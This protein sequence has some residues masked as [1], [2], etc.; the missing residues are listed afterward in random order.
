MNIAEMQ[1][2]EQNVNKTRTNREQN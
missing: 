2:K 1:R